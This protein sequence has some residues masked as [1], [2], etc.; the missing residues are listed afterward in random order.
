M[1]PNR[2]TAPT[3]CEAAFTHTP[4]TRQEPQVPARIHLA[5]IHLTVIAMAA[6]AAIAITCPL[7]AQAPESATLDVKA[8]IISPVTIGATRALDFGRLFANG[9]K[10]VAPNSATSGRI[11]VSGMSGSNI[12]LS[13]TMPSTL[14]TVAGDA[15]S[16]SGWSY[17]MSPDASLAGASAVS[18]ASGTPYPFAA[19]I[20]GISGVSKL[21]LGVGAMVQTVASSPM[22]AY[23]ATGQVT[24]AYADL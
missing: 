13:I 2:S 17:M 7:E 3:V 24:A 12:T 6:L 1:R 10:T 22:G 18:F 23:T 8:Q 20:G 9:S 16:V 15:I 19:T 11:E 21:Y 14:K 5:S 4:L